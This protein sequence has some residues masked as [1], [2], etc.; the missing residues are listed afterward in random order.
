MKGLGQGRDLTHALVPSGGREEWRQQILPG[1]C[2]HTGAHTPAEAC[3]RS[4][5]GPIQTDNDCAVPSLIGMGGAEGRRGKQGGAGAFQ[6]LYGRVIFS[7]FT[8]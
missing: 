1:V 6:P 4:Q 8:K 5:Q 3:E 7:G 2:E